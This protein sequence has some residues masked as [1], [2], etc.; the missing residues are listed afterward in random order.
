MSGRRRRGEAPSL[1]Q[2]PPR[3][4]GPPIPHLP[5]VH[6]HIPPPPSASPH[7]W[8]LTPGL[9]PSPLHYA[10]TH[11][12]PPPI[13]LPSPVVPDAGAA[14]LTSTVGLRWEP[15]MLTVAV[16]LPSRKEGGRAGASCTGEGEGGEAILT[17]AVALPSR[18]E[19]GRAAASDM[20]RE[21]HRGGGRDQPVLEHLPR[22]KRG[23]SAPRHININAHI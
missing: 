18:K 9:P 8:C 11:I 5:P 13:C 2:C 4:S 22:A 12:P 10:H 1:I 20:E 23:K 15:A 19:G 3:V 21:E 14:T 6:T 16:A 7:L 17:V